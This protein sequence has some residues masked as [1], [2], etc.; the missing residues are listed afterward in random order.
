MG[1]IA[2]LVFI[3]LTFLLGIPYLIVKLTTSE[4]MFSADERRRFEFKVKVTLLTISGLLALFVSPLFFFPTM[5][6]FVMVG[7]HKQVDLWNKRRG[8]LDDS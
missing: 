1:G 8:K 6:F 2:V 4:S 3:L 7:W 5:I